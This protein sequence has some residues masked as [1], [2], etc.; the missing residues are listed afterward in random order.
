MAGGVLLALCTVLV[1]E[2]VRAQ[3][4]GNGF[5][6]K[7]PHGSFA[8]RG[9]FDYAIAGSDIFSFTTSQFTLNHSAFNAF[10]LGADLAIRLSPRVDAV[11]GSAYSGKS[12]PSESREFVEGPQNLPI[13]QTTTFQRV[14]VT[15]SVRYYFL[16]R[17]RAI[18]RFA[19]VPAS[20][21]PYVGVGAGAMWYRFR[22]AGDFVDSET[23][24]IS[25]DSFT[26]SGFTPEAHATLGTEFSISPRFAITGEARYTWAKAQPGSDFVG[27]DKIDLS[28]IAA[29]A[30]LAVRF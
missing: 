14:P 2:P 20:F 7:T 24:A 27:F 12:T 19:W 22:Q 13:R 23:M 30:G 29:T 1:A 10:T 11:I 8:V 28:G 9:G 15:A 26:S 21:T 3:S 17:G 4:Q 6:F 5:L 16:P 25:T 18:G